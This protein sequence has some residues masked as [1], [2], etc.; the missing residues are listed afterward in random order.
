MIE[1]PETYVL[2]DQINRTLKGKTIMNV[3]ANA[4]PHKFAWYS[5]DPGT[6]HDKLSGKTI[7]GAT[8]GTGYTCGG[9][10]EILAEDMLLVI[11]TPIRYHE[12]GEKLPA[13]HQ[14]L[15]EFEDFTCMSCT[16][17]MWGAMFC[18]PVKENSL[19]DSFR[20]H[21][22][23]TPLED[24][25]NREYFAGLLAGAKKNLS[26]KAFLATEQRIPGL[27]NG[28]LQDI[29]FNAGVHPKTKLEKLRDEEL[30]NLFAAVKKTLLDMTINGGR[31]TEKDLYGCPGGYR[32]VLSAKTVDEPCRVCGSTIIRE[33]YMGGN[34]YF[35][36]V[37]QKL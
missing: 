29:L 28:V 20:V 6:Y 34:I 4:F 33:A 7:S 25:F 23:P 30:E 13:K 32:T 21:Q 17:Q 11:S 8:P 18:Y 31:D 24:A 37:C 5:G 1:L 10:T 22:G 36:P 19:Q 2:A 26:A 15:V 14:L 9:N 27:G 12:L 35:C 3:T 16:V